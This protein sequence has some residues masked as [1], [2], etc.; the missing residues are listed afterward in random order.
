M[1]SDKDAV[2]DFKD[3]VVI[4]KEKYEKMVKDTERLQKRQQSRRKYYYEHIDDEKE[5]M[6]KYRESED[7]KEKKKIYSKTYYER[8]RERILEQIKLKKQK[9]VS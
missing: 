3:A 1:A 8:N 5:R 2:I 9:N 4:P 7:F 6:K